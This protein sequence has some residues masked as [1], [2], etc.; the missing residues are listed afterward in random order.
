MPGLYGDLTAMPVKDLII[1][2]G[3]KRA[4]GALELTR[5]NVEKKL[6]LREGAVINASSNIPREYLGQFLINLGHITED[7]FTKAHQTQKETGV[8]LGKILVMIGATTEEAVRTSLSLKFRET[9]LDAFSWS[10][11]SFRFE[12]SEPPTATDGVELQIDLLDIHREAEFRETAWTAIRAA[13]PSG[14]LRLELDETKLPTRPLPGSLDERI[15]TLIKAGNTIDEILLALH[16][17]DF[18]LYQRLYALYRLEAVRPREASDEEPAE[19]DLDEPLDEPIVG[20]LVLGEETPASDLLAHAETFLAGGQ[21]AD[22]EALAT[23]AHELAPGP[24]TLAM[25]RRVE[26]ALAEH[27]RRSLLASRTV[28]RLLTSPKQIKELPLTAPERY[29][30]SRVDGQRSF[31]DIVQFSPLREL[32]ALKIFAQL[33]ERKLIGVP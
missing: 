29:V 7:Q 32:E 2:L 9:L 18:L 1:Y 5:G 24:Q 28:P 13:F 22:A 4:T 6:S 30:L 23:K 21:L 15:C 8:F 20:S 33:L 10:D 31:E 14:G 17:T 3:N 25:L 19:L 16:A 27:L 11:G 12:T 26:V